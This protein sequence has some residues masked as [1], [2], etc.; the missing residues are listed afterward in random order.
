MRF[1]IIS[2][3]IFKLSVCS[4]F[5]MP[6]LEL[7][8]SDTIGATIFV[9]PGTYKLQKFSF[10]KSPLTSFIEVGNSPTINFYKLFFPMENLFSAKTIPK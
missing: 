9:Y 8:S 6:S 3:I 4:A 5:H 1:M 2:T 10:P 7:F